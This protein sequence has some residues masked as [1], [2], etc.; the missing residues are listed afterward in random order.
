M[1]P[2]DVNLKKSIISLAKLPDLIV[3]KLYLRLFQEK[4]S[5]IIF[6]FH[7]LFRN[8]KEITLNLVDPQPWITV[9]Q[10]RQFVEYYLDHGYTFISQNDILNGLNND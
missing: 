8:E 2:G 3:S 9:E 5:L 6:N 4:N 1:L 7:G 10:F